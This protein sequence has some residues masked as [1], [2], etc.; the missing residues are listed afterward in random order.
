MTLNLKCYTAWKE[1][2]WRGKLVE[3]KE[4]IR[5]RDFSH[6]QLTT[7]ENTITYHNAPRL[8][9]QHFAQALFSFSLWAILTPKRNWRQCLCKIL[10]WQTKSIIVCYGIFWSG[11]SKTHFLRKSRIA[12]HSSKNR[13]FYYFAKTSLLVT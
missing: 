8:P 3:D 2:L 11:Q 5:D 9:P 4:R 12:R 7:P 13:I 10:E 1:W 6:R